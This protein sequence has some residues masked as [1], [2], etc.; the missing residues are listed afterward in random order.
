MMSRIRLNLLA[1]LTAT[2]IAAAATAALAGGAPSYYQNCASEKQAYEQ[3]KAGQATVS[4]AVA[5]T[6][7]EQCLNDRRY[8]GGQKRP[9][10]AASEC[11][12]RST[13]P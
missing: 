13:C 8:D 10:P 4:A 5:R 12:S 11:H 1:G 6:S 2:A 3:A 9:L 7:L